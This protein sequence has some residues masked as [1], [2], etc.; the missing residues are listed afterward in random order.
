MLAERP[1]GGDPVY[2]RFM[3]KYSAMTS[4]AMLENLNRLKRGEIGE[5][6]FNTFRATVA[7]GAEGMV[8]TGKAYIAGYDEM[9]E[10]AAGDGAMLTKYM[11][12]KRT[13]SV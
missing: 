13:A 2:Q 10:L 12:A 6:E 1:L 11:N 5:Q 8:A 9:A 7:S 4:A 3:G